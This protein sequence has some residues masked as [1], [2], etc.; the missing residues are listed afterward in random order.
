M[1]LI[2][3]FNK[4]ARREERLWNNLNQ[5]KG[6]WLVSG[7]WDKNSIRIYNIALLFAN[8]QEA[9]QKIEK[10]LNWLFQENSSKIKKCL[11]RLVI[12]VSIFNR[13]TGF[14]WIEKDKKWNTQNDHIWSSYFHCMQYSFEQHVQY[15]LFPD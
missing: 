2:E 12:G 3:S 6:I 10:G 8:F 14:S 4:Y 7:D 9:K 15:N 5:I 1:S 13:F 11:L